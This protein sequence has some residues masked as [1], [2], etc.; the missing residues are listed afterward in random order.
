[1]E[2]LPLFFQLRG[3]R[4]LL[5]GGGKV[6]LRKARLLIRA[7]AV[8]SCVSPDIDHELDAMLATSGGEWRNERYRDEH[9]D[10]S[11]LVVAATP[12][13]KVNREVAAGAAARHIPVNVVD[14][15]ELC[16][17]VFP[18]IVDRSPLVIAIS[19]SARSPVLARLVRSKIEALI[20]AAYG[21]LAEFTGRFR[22]A[23]KSVAG[24]EGQRRRFW[25][26]VVDGPVGE[27]VLAGR[28]EEAAVLVQQYLDRPTEAQ[29]V[30]EVYLIGAGPGDPD[31]MSF[32]AARLLQLADVVLYDRLVAPEIVDLARRDAERIY[33]GKRRAD[34]V[35]PQE[36]IN[37][38]LLDLA[39]AGK[40]VARLKGGDPFI[41]GRGGE[42]IGLLASHGVP[43]QVVPG[44]T[45][46]SGCACYAGIPLTH[47]DHAQSV[48]F[49]TGNLKNNRVELPWADLLDEQETLVFYM[50]LKGLETICGSL[51]DHGRSPDTPIAIVEQGTTRNQRTLT[52]TLATLPGQVQG[53]EIHAPTLI[54]VGQVVGLREKLGWYGEAKSPGPWPPTAGS[55][56]HV[57]GWNARD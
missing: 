29:P 56:D 37:Q 35:V 45:A 28:E 31:L 25:E 27:L 41:F 10:E 18:S 57:V 54:I 33:V 3:S 7:G 47:R 11:T 19:S 13:D 48:R 23:V 34:H 42:E 53:E 26:Q 16:S 50:G 12:D 51:Q 46:A 36:Q 24:G 55:E 38:L 6:A 21:R 49:I 40:C 8:V 44:I 14:C 43:F 52:G 22:E 4:V 39:Q 9:L 2:Y 32:K 5:V 20:P 15:P 30:G 1:V 17:F